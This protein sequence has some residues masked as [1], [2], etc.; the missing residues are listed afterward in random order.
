MN[1]GSSRS[2][3]SVSNRDICVCVGSPRRTASTTSDEQGDGDE[4]DGAQVTS[5]SSSSSSPPSSSAVSDAIREH[6]LQLGK[7]RLRQTISALSF[8]FRAV[9]SQKNKGLC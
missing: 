3:A 6:V 8:F 7:V 9:Q 5:S 4:Q 1:G 2:R